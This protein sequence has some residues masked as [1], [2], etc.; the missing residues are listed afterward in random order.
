MAIEYKLRL[1]DSPP[2]DPIEA[3]ARVQQLASACREIMADGVIDA[4]EADA[5]REW[6][7][8]AGWLCRLWPASALRRRLLASI[9]GTEKDDEL[10][11]LLL[12]IAEGCEDADPHAELFDEPV[13]PIEFAGRSFVFTGIFY[14]G[15]RQACIDAITAL[16]G[17]SRKAVSGSTDYLIVGGINHP[18]WRNADSGS[19]IEAAIEFRH[20]YADAL[21]ADL[22]RQE[23]ARARGR[24]ARTGILPPPGPRI[25]REPNWAAAVLTRA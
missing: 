12:H 4:Q 9:N 21:E 23:K 15:T 6:L 19:K 3:R 13:P 25:I 11:K 1:G 17:G 7:K 18:R 16:G 20:I 22:I 5:L 10:S 24:N 14:F 2:S 8:Q